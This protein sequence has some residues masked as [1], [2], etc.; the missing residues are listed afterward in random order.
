MLWHLISPTRDWTHAPCI[1]SAGVLTTGPPGKSLWVTYLRVCFTFCFTPLECKC[2]E[3]RDVL[4]VLFPTVSPVPKAAPVHNRVSKSWL[5]KLVKTSPL[6]LFWRVKRARSY[7]R[8]PRQWDWDE[9][10]ALPPGDFPPEVGPRNPG[11][12]PSVGTLYL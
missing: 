2:Q 10:A 6:L 3:G 8:L 7:L 12:L 5:H 4:S 11:H 9:A 1:G